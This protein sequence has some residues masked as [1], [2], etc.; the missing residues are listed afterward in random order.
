M[1]ALATCSDVVS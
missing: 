1:T